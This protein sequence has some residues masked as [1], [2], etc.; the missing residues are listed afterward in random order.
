MVNP[1]D[2]VLVSFPFSEQEIVT[3]KKR[4]VLVLATPGPSGE[5]ALWVM[6][7][8][9]NERRFA[10]PSSSD[11]RLDDWRD[12]GLALPSVLRTTRVWT[13]E[14]RDVVRRIG[15]CPSNVLELAKSRVIAALS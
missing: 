7:I 3:Y 13:A 4:P 6:M 15:T 10:R 1:A 8:T 14:E 11:I 5:S 2:V 9:G 12:V